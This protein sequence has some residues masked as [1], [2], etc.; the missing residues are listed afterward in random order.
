[1]KIASA[2][3]IAL[4]LLVV[5]AAGRHRD[6]Q[7]SPEPLTWQASVGPF[8]GNVQALAETDSGAVFAFA[9][10]E[11]FRSTDDG[12]TW[13]RCPSQPQRRPGADISKPWLVAAGP[14]PC[15]PRHRY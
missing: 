10:S 9:N 4:G 1:M 5:G 11:I 15:A 2:L 13:V 12:V 7:G 6:E 8:A 3:A 14:P